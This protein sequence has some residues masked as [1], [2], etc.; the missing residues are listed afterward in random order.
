VPDEDRVGGGLDS[1]STPEIVPDPVATIGSLDGE[2]PAVVGE[3][4]RAVSGG[5]WN[6]AS[7]VVPMASTLLLSVIIQRSLGSEALGQQSL[8]AFVASLFV[9]LPVM[10]VV[11]ASVQSLSAARGRGNGAEIAWLSKMSTLFHVAAGTVSAVAIAVIGLGR[12]DLRSA[13][14]LAAATVLLDSAG[15]SMSAR[16]A[17][18]EGWTKIG[19]RR[20]L[21]QVASPLLGVA[22]LLAGWGVTGVFAGQAVAAFVLVV[23]LRPVRPALPE[24]R[25]GER[26]PSLRPL[27]VLWGTFG[28]ASVI[29]Q[30]VERRVEVVF[31][32][33][34]SGPEQIAMYSIAFNLVSIAYYV[35]TSGIGAATASISAV[36][37]S[38]GHQ[39]VA[40]GL[41]RSARVVFVF[42]ALT[43]VAIGT[44]GP[45]VIDTVYKD[46]SA[47]AAFIPWLCLTLLI[48]PVGHLVQ[49]YWTGVAR[50]KPVLI[51]GALGAVIDIG[52]AVLLIPRFDAAGAVAA[53]VIAQC[54]AAILIIAYTVRRLG[55]LRLPPRLV[56]RTV[57]VLAPSGVAA[58]FLSDLGGAVGI[59]AGAA[60][61]LVVAALLTRFVAVLDD[62]DL[63]W[64]IGAVPARLGRL[65]G[66][67]GRPTFR[68]RAGRSP[69]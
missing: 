48:A 66:W 58:A 69:R 1:P 19:R 54:V 64:L 10:S 41:A 5:F 39:R 43:A 6:A 37:A 25:A 40:E 68:P 55:Y 27:L 52:L 13:W 56:I 44:V 42:G 21:T 49:A 2:A 34:Y 22:A 7:T 62:A 15:W 53:N 16:I 24:V 29:T 23:L 3:R 47:A 18:H 26:R 33:A 63:A 50:M 9:S 36:S 65:I 11:A 46:A 8:I 4:R 67:A 30:I 35:C 14:F 60:G 28:M 17:A 45:L 51:V 31:L 59:A 38:G 57:V 61:F 20:L 32:D 12:D